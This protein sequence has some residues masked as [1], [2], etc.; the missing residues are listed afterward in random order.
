MPHELQRLV[1]LRA[2]RER[3][4]ERALA[5]ERDLL[6]CAERQ[7]EREQQALAR[8]ERSAR[9]ARERLCSEASPSSVADAN[10][11]LA[12]AASRRHAA[13]DAT[14]SVRRA[15][16]EIAQAEQRVAGAR[17]TWQ[18]RARAHAKMRHHHEALAR[19]EAAATVRRTEDARADE[20]LDGWIARQAR[21]AGA[22]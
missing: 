21:R 2:W 18:Q 10:Q 8:I 9:D 16:G 6:R 7:R 15:E 20:H 4:A 3:A 12:Y 17:D 5:A 22:R 14:L 1:D 11:L 19:D 13:V